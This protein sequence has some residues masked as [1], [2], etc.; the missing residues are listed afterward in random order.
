MVKRSRRRLLPVVMAVCV[1]QFSSARGGRRSSDSA[2]PA[3]PGVR[4]DDRA[5]KS[6]TPQAE[7][8]AVNQGPVGFRFDTNLALNPGADLVGAWTSGVWSRNSSTGVWTQISTSSAELIAAGD[9]D[10]DGVSDLVGAWPESGLWVR[11]S[12]TGSWQWI[13]SK[14]AS[15]AV[16][17][18]NGDHK[19]EIIG[20][21]D[22]VIWSR[23]GATGRWT[24][25]SSGA[26]QIALGDMD[27][28]GKDD[29]AGTWP[30]GVWVKYTSTGAWARL[31]S[32]ADTIACG[33][34]D[35]DGKSDL[36]GTWNGTV[37]AMNSATSAWTILTSGAS[38]ITAGDLDGD[39]KDDLIG[40]WEASGVWVK[41]SSNGTWSNLSKSAPRCITTMRLPASQA[42]C[43]AANGL[44]IDHHSDIT[45]NETWAGDGTVH[46][47]SSDISIRPGATLTLA[48][49]S[50]VQ[51]T[52][53]KSITVRGDPGKPAKLVSAGTA[54]KPVLITNVPGGGNWGYLRNY[55][56]DSS[57]DLSYTTLENGGKG[58]NHGASLDFNGSSDPSIV[59]VPMV[60]ADHLAVKNSIGTGIVMEG[61]AGF[62]GD[63]TDITVTGGGSDPN[64]TPAAAI[65]ITQLAA[66]TLPVLHIS[67]NA[68]NQITVASNLLIIARNLTLRNLGVP[69]YFR[70]DRVRVT[71]P[72]GVFAPT[73]TIQPGAELRFDDYLVVGD[74]IAGSSVPDHPGKLLALGTATQPILFT[75]PKALKAAGDWPGIWLKSA[76][77]S[78]IENARIEYAGGWNGIVSANCR[79]DGSDDHAGLFIGWNGPYIPS[80]GDFLNVTIANSASHGINAMWTTGSFGPDLTGGFMF[81]NINGCRQTRNGITAG[82]GAN[83]K[84]CL[85]Q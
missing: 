6:V 55:T 67:G 39:G 19:A 75:S 62:T 61:G 65:E 11:Y 78:R 28:D 10:G 71:D 12:A 7:H 45:V 16:G 64:G 9:I 56:P 52:S 49:C 8:Q 47:I 84:G 58:T 31:A 51:V 48:A 53:G 66:G 60:K 83:G 46:K 38:Q 20:I 80:P 4:S 79:P 69:Y 32:S 63:S 77:G 17:D 44:S 22:S 5:I 26:S 21:W 29:L 25:L 15:M 85:V 68:G 18:T 1:F 43:P 76:A 57:A 41:Y 74:Y 27:G 14:P 59:V 73:L 42:G 24:V 50:Q 3:A 81:L 72:T 36:L 40:V 82:C 34:L 70:F 33:D 35:G 37:W 2:Y 13:T 23:D 54:G 30:G